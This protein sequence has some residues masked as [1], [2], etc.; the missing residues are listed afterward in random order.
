[1]LRPRSPAAFV[2]CLL[3]SSVA[4]GQGK[5]S[6]A[7]FAEGKALMDQG[8]IPEA[9]AR[10]E[11]SLRLAERGGTLLNLAVCREREGR[12]A[13][14]LALFRRARERAALDHRDDR[15]S[16]AEERLRALEQT[17]SSLRVH[18][19]PGADSSMLAVLLDGA[20]L[21][22]DHWDVAE[23]VDPGV[24]TVVATAPGRTRFEATVR[25]G[26]GGVRAAEI[27]IPSVAAVVQAPPVEAPTRPPLV[28]S[29]PVVEPPAPAPPPPS[30]RA[31]TG[32]VS[33]GLGIASVAV[34]A[35]FGIRTIEDANQSNSA[36]PHGMCT[37]SAAYDQDLDARTYAHVADVTIPLGLVLAAAGTYL[38]LTRHSSSH[39]QVGVS[40]GVTSLGGSF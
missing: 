34:G 27:E 14:A 4:W 25:V 29:P 7:A 28:L 8:H 32:W 5:E 9:C 12:F 30:W 17:V 13:T 38:V 18:L 22:R 21:P 6:D 40:P 37:T 31:P 3:T 11:A 2:F 24:H 20:P 15:A 35:G 19:A 26:E 39:P 33:L 36:C 16:L 1:V 10:F 23:L